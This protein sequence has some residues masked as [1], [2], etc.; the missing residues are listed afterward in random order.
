MTTTKVIASFKFIAKY[1]IQMLISGG[2]LLIVLGLIFKTTGATTATE[3][4]IQ[5]GTQSMY[6][7]GGILALGVL[8]FILYMYWKK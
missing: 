1:P 5:I 4:L 6:W 7:G 2:L 3:A 8:V